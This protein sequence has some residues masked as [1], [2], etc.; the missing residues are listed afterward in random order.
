MYHIFAAQR[1][2]QDGARQRKNQPPRKPRSSDPPTRHAWSSLRLPS[3][4]A[5]AAWISKW[6]LPAARGLLDLLGAG[7][8]RA[9]ARFEPE[10]VE[11]GLA[12]RGLD[13]LAEVVG[14]V[15]VAG[16][17]GAGERALQLALG[18]RGFE[19]GAADADPRAAAIGA[20]ADVG[21]D[22]AVGAEREADQLVA[23]RR[24]G[25][26]G[27]RSARSPWRRGS[28]VRPCV[29]PGWSGAPSVSF[30]GFRNSV[31]PGCSALRLRTNARG[32]P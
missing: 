24:C 16:L 27:R 7:E 6:T 14:N 19:R 17:E 23:R 15:E 31:L 28:R 1:H 25:A 10:A 11:R 22:L 32:R 9:A 12:Q 8:Q 2:R 26:R 13:A 4:P 5:S 29:G 3:S 20:G 21:R 18:L 30:R